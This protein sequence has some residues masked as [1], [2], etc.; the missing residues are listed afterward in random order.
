MCPRHWVN[1]YE[2]IQ[3]TC[4]HY[5]FE[6]DISMSI[7]NLFN[8]FMG[9]SDPN[10]AIKSDG[11]TIQFG[12]VRGA[13]AGS[14]LSLVMGNRAAGKVAA[15]LAGHGGA[16]MLGS[17]AFKAYDNWKHECNEETPMATEMNFHRYGMEQ[18]DVQEDDFQMMTMKVMIAAAKTNASIDTREQKK[19]LENINSLNLTA[20]EKDFM[21]ELFHSDLSIAEITNESMS[22]ELKSEIYLAARLVIDAESGVLETAFLKR[23]T[24]VL[25]LPE[26]FVNQLD[27]QMQQALPQAA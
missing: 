1:S 14:I 16:S 22:V 20:Q 9:V 26:A 17:V 8:Q 24:Q 4:S 19:N 12:P 11:R 25:E 3:T 21:L 13:S 7:N 23:L 18:S 10:T 27:F 5:Y 15:N 6:E 2:V